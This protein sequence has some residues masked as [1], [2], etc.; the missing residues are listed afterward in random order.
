M[1][2][3]CPCGVRVNAFAEGVNVKFDGV[4]GNIRGNLTYLANVCITTLSTSTLSLRFEDTETPD[5]FSFLF[6]ANE[7]TDVKCKREGKNC[8]IKV[9]GTGLIG[10]TE[11]PFKAVFRDQV[12]TA[13][14]DL[15][16]SFVIKGFFDQD[17]TVP[18]EQGSVVALG[19]QC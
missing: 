17:G 6:T 1:G 10:M 9:R 8:V 2:G 16:Q 4:S 19:C 15:V 11:Y 5:H 3:V 12:A 18:V 13:N 14:N 7:I